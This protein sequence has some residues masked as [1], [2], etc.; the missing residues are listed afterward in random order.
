[1]E[2]KAVKHGTASS[3]RFTPYSM[4]RKTEQLLG[5]GFLGSAAG[6]ASMRSAVNLQRPP[7]RIDF[8]ARERRRR[9]RG[10]RGS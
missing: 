5:L 8:G 6:A 7:S 2:N 4:L 9:S 1:M 10:G 3:K